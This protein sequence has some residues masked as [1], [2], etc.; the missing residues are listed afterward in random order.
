VRF[1]RQRSGFVLGYKGEIAVSDDHLIVAQRVT[2]NQTDNES[3][4]SSAADSRPVN[5]WPTAASFPK[6]TWNSWKHKRSTATYRIR[7]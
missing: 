7:T 5:C 1:P 3:L 4:L 6:P 2:Q